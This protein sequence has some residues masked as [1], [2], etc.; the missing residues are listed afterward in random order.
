[1]IPGDPAVLFAGPGHTDPVYLEKIRRMMGLDKPLHLQFLSYITKLITLDLGFS[2]YSGNPITL[3]IANRFPATLELTI[4][5]MLLALIIGIPLAMLSA[6]KRGSKLDYLIRSTSYCALGIPS[7][8]FGIMLI[9]VFYYV[10]RWLPP[11][12]RLN[13]LLTPPLRITGMYLLDSLLTGNLQC[14]IDALKHIIL[15]AATLSITLLPHIIRLTR[16]SLIEVLNQDYITTAKAK[17]LNERAILYKHALKN[18]ILPTI[19]WV[20]MAFGNLLGGAIA[21]EYIYG[22]PGVGT[23]LFNSIFFLDYE[24][25]MSCALI[26][27]FVFVLCNLIVDMIYAYIDPRIRLG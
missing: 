11:S 18:A 27:T 17:G 12:G 10:L 7:F 22:W 21:I 23:Y 16:S 13:P 25:I 3:D 6:S 8:W 9:Y 24:A 15:P 26:F 14:F 5:S 1:V 4:V 19:S 20:G 2:W